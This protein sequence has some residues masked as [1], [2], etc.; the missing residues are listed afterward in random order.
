MRDMARIRAELD[1]EAG[2]AMSGDERKKLN[3]GIK[4]RGHELKKLL[5]GLDSADSG[6]V[7][8]IAGGDDRAAQVGA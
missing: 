3:S 4:W 6:G 7:R 1:S 5:E 2:R 8:G